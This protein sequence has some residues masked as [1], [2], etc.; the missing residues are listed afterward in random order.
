MIK[1]VRLVIDPFLGY[2]HARVEDDKQ[3][4]LCGEHAKH[5][6]LFL[7]PY[8]QDPDKSS[9]QFLPDPGCLSGSQWRRLWDRWNNTPPFWLPFK[10][11]SVPGTAAQVESERIRKVK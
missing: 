4:T 3:M 1:N 9:Q 11:G 8:V 7:P 2:T 5:W 10:P 6:E